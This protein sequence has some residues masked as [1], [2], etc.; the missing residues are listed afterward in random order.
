MLQKKVR[1]YKGNL[2]EILNIKKL[3]RIPAKIW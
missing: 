2:I 3:N 1:K